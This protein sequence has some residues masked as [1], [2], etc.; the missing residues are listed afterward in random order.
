VN[1]VLGLL[2]GLMILLSVPVLVETSGAGLSR[3]A[4][5]AL[6]VVLPA[7]ALFLVQ[8][9]SGGPTVPEVTGRRG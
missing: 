9:R 8:R 3:L 7:T 1:L 5:L 2:A 6:L 4:L